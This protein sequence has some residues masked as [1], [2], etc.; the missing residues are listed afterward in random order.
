MTKSILLLCENMLD[1]HTSAN[2]AK[3]R[4]ITHNDINALNLFD[5]F[6]ISIFTWQK[7]VSPLANLELIDI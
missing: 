1:I 4:A 2:I 7:L 5:F 6:I 3:L